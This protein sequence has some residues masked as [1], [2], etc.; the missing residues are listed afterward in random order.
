MTTFSFA[1]IGRQR[2]VPA[3]K[4]VGN[5]IAKSESD[6]VHGRPGE[7]KLPPSKRELLGQHY[8]FRELTPI[9]LDQLCSCVATRSIKR[10][11]TILTKGDPGVWLFIICKGHV[12]ISVPTI[13]GHDAVINL[14]EDGDIFGEFALLDGRP[15][16]AD[17]KAIT[18]C[19]ML[20]VG[21]RDFLPLL[22]EQPQTA[23]H[24]I[25][26]LCARIRK[27]V[28]QTENLMY[29]RLPTRLATA[30]LQLAGDDRKGR[31]LTVA[32]TQSDLAGIIGM[33][34]EN[35]N[36]QLRDWQTKKWLRLLRGG[37]ILLS[38]D[39]LTAIAESNPAV[40]NKMV[41]RLADRRA[42]S[43]VNAPASNR[44]LPALEGSRRLSAELRARAARP[45]DHVED[46]GSIRGTSKNR[47][48][49]RAVRFS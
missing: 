27:A 25:E 11:A 22:R 23:L 15:Q 10:G 4:R 47:F 30:L 26:I 38:P 21:R 49:D 7:R 46:V 45:D 31:G 5:M 33:A 13:D 20:V 41:H 29:R 42:L 43:R 34:R 37:I 24:L 36:K 1:L 14:L 35:I 48:P 17:A 28:E 16:P 44:R 39:E 32:V 6:K 40:S 8:I 12:K 2:L 3:S 9:H 19:E 18:D